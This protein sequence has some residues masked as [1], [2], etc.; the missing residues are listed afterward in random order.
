[1]TIA[2]DELSRII[3][4]YR[5]QHGTLGDRDIRPIFYIEFPS[6]S[7]RAARLTLTFAST[8]DPERAVMLSLDID[9]EGRVLG[10]EFW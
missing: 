5:Q 10:I 4:D 9:G 7:N 8:G 6:E 3:E 2:F 1:M